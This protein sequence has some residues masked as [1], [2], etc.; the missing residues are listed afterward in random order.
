L[1]EALLEIGDRQLGL[2][3]LELEVMADNIGAIR[4]YEQCGFVVEGRKRDAVMRPG[5][6]VDLLVMGRL[7]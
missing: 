6:F 1:L 4:L 5:G 7:R 2:T 3:R